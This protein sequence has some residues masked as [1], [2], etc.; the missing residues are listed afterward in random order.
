MAFVL[1]K[2][3]R[4]VAVLLVVTFLAYAL[5]SAGNSD[6]IAVATSAGIG[7]SSAQAAQVKQ[8]L[9]LNDGVVVG[10]GKWLG[11]AV[12][13]DLGQSFATHQTVTGL[14]RHR[15][16]VSLQL[17]LWAQLLALLLAVPLGILSAFRSGSRTDAA[18]TTTSFALLSVPSFVLGVLLVFLF[19]L[20]LHWFPAIHHQV[21]FLHDPGGYARQ[22]FLPSLTLALGLLAVYVRL[23]RTDMIATLQ[24]DYIGVARAKGLPT[25]RIL[26]RHA[27]RPSSFSLLTVGG[28]QVGQ[29][30]GGAI[31]VEQIFNVN[32]M[33]S[34]IVQ[35]IYQRDY[36]V[37]Q[38]AATVICAAYVIVNVGVDLLYAVLDPRLRHVRSVA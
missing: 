19:S 13:G 22:Y 4:L 7:A 33:G 35:A 21:S 31:I 6:D 12:H 11:R 5:L 23:L 8:D 28:I 36:F 25:S 30:I 26:L 34:A 27:L 9:G 15:V 38:G 10:Y 18:I 29:L 37:V 1:R 16:P 17:M 3:A 32:G 2:V 14:L 20:K 24:E